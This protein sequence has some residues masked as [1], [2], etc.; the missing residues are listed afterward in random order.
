M[1]L[2]FDFNLLTRLSPT[3]L[4]RCLP[5]KGLVSAHHAI[6]VVLVVWSQ[7]QQYQ[8]HLETC[9]EM[10]VLRFQPRPTD[11]ETVSGDQNPGL[12]SPQC[13][14][15]AQWSR[16]AIELIQS[17]QHLPQPLVLKRA[18]SIGVIYSRC[19]MWH[20][21]IFYISGFPSAYQKK[22]PHKTHSQNMYQSQAY[23]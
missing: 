3:I 20:G 22:K 17:I 4:W 9:L 16:R 15:K 11:S 10:Q 18:G 1:S 5:L 23:K 21:N 2:K 12:I 7:D 14:S 19:Q 6:P 13:D 8:Y